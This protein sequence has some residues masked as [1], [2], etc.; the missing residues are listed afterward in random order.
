MFYTVHIV[1]STLIY[2]LIFLSVIGWIY[3][4]FKRRHPL[5]KNIHPRAKKRFDVHQWRSTFMQVGLIIALGVTL[6][7]FDFSIQPS[8]I[9]SAHY[10]F[11]LHDIQEVEI[12]RVPE[13]KIK[14]PKPKHIP[15]NIPVEDL[16]TPASVMA[17]HEEPSLDKYLPEPVSAPSQPAPVQ[18]APP[19]PP[20][21]QEDDLPLIMAEE[22]PRFPGCEHLSKAD[23]KK[24][25]EKEM[26]HYISQHIRYPEIARSN[27]VQ[28]TCVISFVVNKKGELEDL[29]IL[30]DIG[31]RCGQ[32]ALR[33]VKTMK[34]EKR[35]IPGKQRG[36]KVSVRFNLPI[37]FKLR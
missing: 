31:A 12:P 1:V 27:D 24:C 36:R 29:K 13:E 35:W 17:I 34:K 2:S 32:E 11:D 16:P 7:A 33:V 30:R 14:L 8:D 9:Q 20:P 10:H 5:L 4:F 22:M 28:G 18:I 3:F 23:R 25:A 6:L 26:L 15:I 19:P 21:V 37:K